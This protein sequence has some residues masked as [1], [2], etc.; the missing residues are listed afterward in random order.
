MPAGLIENDDRVGTGGYCCGDLIEV[1]LHGFGVTERQNQGSTG[2][3]FGTDRT[4]QSIPTLAAAWQFSR[5]W[6]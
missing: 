1:K 6:R 5:S 3:M 2:S 4:E